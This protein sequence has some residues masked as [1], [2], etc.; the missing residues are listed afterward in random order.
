MAAPEFNIRENEGVY[1][2]LVVLNSSLQFMIKRLEEIA[3]SK[4][5]DA[6]YLNK[7]S[8]LSQDV[9]R[10]LDEMNKPKTVK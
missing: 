3:A 2:L 5:L 7:M 6:E 1:R 8:S 9:Q 10:A 4:I